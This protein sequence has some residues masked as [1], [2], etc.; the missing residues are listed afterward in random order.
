MPIEIVGVVVA[1]ILPITAAV[2][3]GYALVRTGRRVEVDT[4][5]TL[6]IDFAMPALVFGT[7]ARSVV[8]WT[9]FAKMA[10]AGVLSLALLGVLGAGVLYC[11]GL[12]LRTYVPSLTWGNGAFV[13]YPVALYAFGDIGL[14]HAIAFAAGSQIF[15]CTVV[16]A[17]AAGV[18]N[19]KAVVRS[20]LIYAIIGGVLV[21][22]TGIDI[23]KAVLNG[24]SLLGGM[25]V[26]LMLIL[27]P[28]R[29]RLKRG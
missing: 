12:R 28:D 2:A 4:L 20:P 19:W 13:G 22:L 24:C 27:E 6:A 18:A 5:T 25:T 11:Y 23:P 10:G 8:P 17:Y 15:N 21:Q 29:F 26:P 3:I 14:S 1:T 7:L 9:E 16:Q